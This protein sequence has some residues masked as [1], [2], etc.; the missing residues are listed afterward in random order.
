MNEKTN[1]GKKTKSNMK[2]LIFSL[3]L[4]IAIA[5]SFLPGLFRS[6][7]LFEKSP[8]L[9]KEPIDF[10]VIDAKELENLQSIPK[11]KKTLKEIASENNTVIINFFAS[12]CTECREER[13][14]LN[15]IKKSDDKEKLK[16]VGVVFQDSK[17]KILNYLRELNPYDYI[18]FDKGETAID[19]GVSGVPETFVIINGKIV[20]KFIGPIS[21]YEIGKII[22]EEKKNNNQEE[23]QIKSEN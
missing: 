18:Y 2:W 1:T 11:N 20:K 21:I 6:K 9:G 4:G 8:L 3:V 12:W 19:Y 22:E 5:L 16:I 23:K 15:E 10:E 13:V 7:K 14:K 17:E